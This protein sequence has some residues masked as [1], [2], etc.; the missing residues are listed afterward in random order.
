M[1]DTPCCGIS[2][3]GA[4]RIWAGDKPAL[5]VVALRSY[6]Y[7]LLHLLKVIAATGAEGGKPHYNDAGR[8]Q[9][10]ETCYDGTYD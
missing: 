7:L 3:S 6:L 10:Q 2:D 4:Y 5:G 8:R 9:K 1:P